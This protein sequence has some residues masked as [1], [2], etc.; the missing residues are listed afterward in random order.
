ML[1]K[2]LDYEKANKKG[3]VPTLFKES[4]EHGLYKKG[5][6]FK[7]NCLKKIKSCLKKELS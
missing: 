4:E 7:K 3:H 2:R 5:C 1:K 6:L